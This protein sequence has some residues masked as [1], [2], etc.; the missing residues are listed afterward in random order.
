MGDINSDCGNNHM[1]GQSIYDKLNKLT[2]YKTQ[3]RHEHGDIGNDHVT[4]VVVKPLQTH[5]H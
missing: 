1:Q 5:L 2:C 4:Y 3:H